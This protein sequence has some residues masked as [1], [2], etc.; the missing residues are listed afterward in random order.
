MLAVWN[1]VH[2]EYGCGRVHVPVR[3]FTLAACLRRHTMYYICLIAQV[4]TCF[5]LLFYELVGNSHEGKSSD[6]YRRQVC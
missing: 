4:E 6:L 1:G 5:Y 3:H 2:V